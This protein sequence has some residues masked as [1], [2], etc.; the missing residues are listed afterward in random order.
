MSKRP[1]MV[2]QMCECGDH[3][4]ARAALG[5]VILVSPEDEAALDV[6]W[7]IGVSSKSRR[8]V[9][10]QRRAPDGDGYRSA[11]LHREIANAPD[12]MFVDHKNLNSLDNRRSNI[13]I[14][15]PQQNL[16]NRPPYR[17]KAVPLKGV[18]KAPGGRF[19]A[20]IRFN[21]QVRHLGQFNTP[22][23]A[24]E[25]YVRAAQELHGEFFRAA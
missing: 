2:R 12:G 5:F 10:A 22:E 4:W 8:Y 25:A 21:S 23:E 18:Q 14:C 15:T 6:H 7:C 13:R 20:V 16:L 1:P 19:K 24:H 9:K 3:V 11:S 17:G